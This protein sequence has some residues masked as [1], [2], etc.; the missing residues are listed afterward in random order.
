MV[1]NNSQYRFV[2]STIIIC[3]VKLCLS[4]SFV[5]QHRYS[6]GIWNEY[7]W[8]TWITM[9]LFLEMLLIER[10]K[11]SNCSGWSS[12]KYVYTVMAYLTVVCVIPGILGT[13]Q[14]HYKAHTNPILIRSDNDVN[15]LAYIKNAILE[16]ELAGESDK[17]YSPPELNKPWRHMN[18]FQQAMS[19]NPQFQVRQINH[20]GCF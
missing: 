11:I 12:K 20:Q 2:L 6:V 16:Q 10:K 15:K 17:E 1:G 9:I 18:Y 19:P 5:I 13:S 7:I 8:L 4:C 3:N 14:S